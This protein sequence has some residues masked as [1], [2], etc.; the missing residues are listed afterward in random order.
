MRCAVFIGDTLRST[1]I[2][3]IISSYFGYIEV[4]A[5]EGVNEDVKSISSQYDYLICDSTNFICYNDLFLPRASNLLVV[6][7]SDSLSFSCRGYKTLSVFAS[8]ET[9]VQGIRAL[10][11]SGRKSVPSIEHDLTARETDVLK[12]IAKGYLNKEIASELCISLN[13][14]L[15][16]RKNITSKLGIKTVSGLAFYAYVNGLLSIDEIQY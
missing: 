6:L 9:I 11:E 7:D 12:L 14:V 3:S 2:V 5:F 10:F 1:G 4:D 15:S 16:H 13:T 8:R